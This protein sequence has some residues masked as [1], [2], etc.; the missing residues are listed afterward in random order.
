[1]MEVFRKLWGEK[2]WGQRM[3]YILRNALLTLLDQPASDVTHTQ[4][5]LTDKSFRERI[6][7]NVEHPPVR[8]FWLKEFKGYSYRY[9][10][11]AI[12]PIQSKIGAFLS[13]PRLYRILV[14]PKQPLS[15]R[16]IMD[17]G[18]ILLVNLSVG[19]IGTDSAAL[20]GGLLVTTLG[21]AGMSRA[22]MPQQERRPHCLYLDE[23]QS[24]TTLSMA[25]MLSEI[26]KMNIGM[27]MAHQYLHQLEPGIRHAVLGNSGTLVSFRVGAEDAGFLAKE[28]Q[29]IFNVEDLINLPNF[30]MYLKL[31]VEG[32]PSKPFSAHATI[33]DEKTWG[34]LKETDRFA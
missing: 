16:S 27:C 12:A 9:R 19:Q 23:F 30:E 15:L 28:F 25:T 1:M 31:M 7:R 8:D 20:L 10:A 2:A 26:R 17:Q 18:K 5:V 29:P 4:R 22:D 24:F 6:A 33:N 32:T 13:D 11:E 3:E 14:E 21:L 34:Y